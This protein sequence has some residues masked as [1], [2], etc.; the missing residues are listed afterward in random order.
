MSSEEG[1][2]D[3]LPFILRHCIL[4]HL[5]SILSLKVLNFKN[6][7]HKAH[8]NT[9]FLGVQD[10]IYA[11]DKLIKMSRTKMNVLFMRGLL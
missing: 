8:P 4:S 5:R 11:Q 7:H 6:T 2:F 10:V 1:L 9:D 3:N